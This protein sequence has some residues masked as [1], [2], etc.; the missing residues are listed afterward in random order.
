MNR[1]ITIISSPILYDG[2]LS[3]SAIFGVII[4]VFGGI[5]VIIMFIFTIIKNYKDKKEMKKI[6]EVI[7]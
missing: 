1:I 5:L 3:A 4:L 2:S 6:K 7:D